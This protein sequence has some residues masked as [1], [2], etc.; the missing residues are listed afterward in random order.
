MEGP[1]FKMT[2]SYLRLYIGRKSDIPLYMYIGQIYAFYFDTTRYILN[3]IVNT[4]SIWSKK[5]FDRRVPLV[6][7]WN[8]LNEVSNSTLVRSKQK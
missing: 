7:Y 6:L 5:K 3:D 1:L 4:K 8:D 2:S